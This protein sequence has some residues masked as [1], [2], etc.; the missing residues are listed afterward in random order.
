MKFIITLLLVGFVSMTWCGKECKCATVKYTEGEEMVIQFSASWCG[1]CH[2]LKST[3]DNST[4]IQ[5]HIKDNMRGYYLID[6]E[7]ASENEKKWIKKG[8]DGG[9]IPCV[10]KYK[11]TKGKWVETNRFVGVQSFTFIL[12]WLKTSK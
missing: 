1:P 11:Y 6:V 3:V 8:Y 4:L 5:K 7:S 2:S 10:V 9:S 12:R